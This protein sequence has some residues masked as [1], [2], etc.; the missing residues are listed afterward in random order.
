MPPITRGD[1]SEINTFD[2]HSSDHSL[3]RLLRGGDERAAET[4]YRRY[5]RRVHALIAGQLP[6]RLAPRISPDDIAQSVFRVLFHGLAER[7]YD[8]PRDHELWGLLCALALSKVRDRVAYHQAARR[9]VRRTAAAPDHTLAAEADRVSESG[10]LCLEVEDLLQAFHA[11]DRQ[12]VSL[13]MAGHE[14]LEISELTGRSL[15]TVERVLQK[16]RNRLRDALR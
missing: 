14:V 2:A 13:R 6:D 10:R 7:T 12:I 4:L 11:D 8:V 1:V 15:R 9:D 16:A 3:V 5:V